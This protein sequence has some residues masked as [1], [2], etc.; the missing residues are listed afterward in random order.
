M[1][2]VG[3]FYGLGVGPGD[4]DLITMKAVKIL[5]RVDTVFTASSSTNEY[6]LA[7]RIGLKYLR[8]GVETRNLPFPMTEDEVALNAAWRA[9]AATIAEVLRSGRSAAFLTL[10]DCL[11]Y[12]TYAYLLPILAEIIPE[13]PIV[14]VPGITSYQLAAARLNR[15]LAQTKESLAILSGGG[16]PEVFETLLDHSDNVV[17]M[18][19]GRVREEIVDL[20]KKKNLAPKTALFAKLGLDGEKIDDGL[21]QELD[22]PTYFSLMLV[23]KRNKAL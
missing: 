7:R 3:S 23:T 16:D 4:P 12:S 11:T 2:K 18:K 9:N 8:A 5:N 13:A 15:P 10:G 19:M 14:S 17:I 6:S 20:L 22:P 1:S 21:D